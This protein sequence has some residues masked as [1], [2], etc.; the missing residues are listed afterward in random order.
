MTNELAILL[1]GRHIALIRDAA[2]LSF[3]YRWHYSI[4]QAIGVY[5]P[6]LTLGMELEYQALGTRQQTPN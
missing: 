3:G 5:M 6:L 2:V 1:R 4:H